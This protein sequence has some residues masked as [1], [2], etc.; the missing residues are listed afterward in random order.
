M[1]AALHAGRPEAEATVFFFEMLFTVKGTPSPIM[2]AIAAEI[3]ATTS[4]PIPSS[5]T[6]AGADTAFKAGA[7]SAFFYLFLKMKR[8]CL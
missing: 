6:G 5:T 4:S 2:Q 8:F 7:T 3:A 1:P